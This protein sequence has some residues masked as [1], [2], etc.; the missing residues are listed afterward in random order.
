MAPLRAFGPTALRR[1]QIVFILV[2]TTNAVNCL[3]RD[4]RLPR[5]VFEEHEGSL[6][7]SKHGLRTYFLYFL[8]STYLNVFRIPPANSSYFLADAAVVS[9]LFSRK[10]SPIMRIVNGSYR[11]WGSEK[12]FIVAL[13]D[14]R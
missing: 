5:N 14:W 3:K 12:T 13:V 6:D 1:L 8:S 9:H 7:E 10:K 4:W 11:V 2:F